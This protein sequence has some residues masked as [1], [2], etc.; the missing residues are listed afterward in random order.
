MY[1]HIF[2]ER[3]NSVV[4]DMFGKLL[5]QIIDDID[6]PSRVRIEACWAISW[7]GISNYKFSE[8]ITPLL[9]SII[10][11][12][13]RSKEKKGIITS[14]F[15]ALMRS[16]LIRY[17][18]IGADN[19]DNF[20]WFHNTISDHNLLKVTNSNMFKE[21]FK[22]I[23][24]DEYISKIEDPN[25]LLGLGSMFSILER[26]EE[27]A[28]C[29]EESSWV[30]DLY[31][32]NFRKGLSLMELAE[33][34]N[35][36][37]TK[38]DDL[39]KAKNYFQAALDVLNEERFG[40]NIT[41]LEITKFKLNL[42]EARSH[43]LF[44]IKE[45]G[46]YKLNAD[47]TLFKNM[48]YSFDLSN[49]RYRN[50]P[51]VRIDDM[52]IL[53]LN[54][55][56]L[57]SSVCSKL[58]E[59]ITKNELIEIERN[60]QNLKKD[61][62]NGY[63]NF[64]QNVIKILSDISIETNRNKLIEKISKIDFPQ[65]I[66]NCPLSECPT[67]KMELIDLP[68]SKGE[69]YLINGYDKSIKLNYYEDISFYREK[70][71][72]LKIY[73]LKDDFK[74]NDQKIIECIE[75]E[76]E[77]Y[78]SYNNEQKIFTGLRIR[79]K[80][81][82][83]CS[84]RNYEISLYNIFSHI[85]KFNPT[86]WPFLNKTKDNTSFTIKLSASFKACS[87]RSICN[88]PIRIFFI[89]EFEYYPN[90]CILMHDPMSQT[91]N[92]CL[93]NIKCMNKKEVFLSYKFSGNIFDNK[94]KIKETQLI[95]RIKNIFDKYSINA[96]DSIEIKGMEGSR[97]CELCEK[98]LTRKFF[99]AELSL[100]SLNVWFEIGLSMA[101]NK[102][103]Y[104]I[105]HQDYEKRY[106]NV[107]ALRFPFTSIYNEGIFDSK[108]TEIAK[109]IQSF[110]VT[111]YRLEAFS[112]KYPKLDESKTQFRTDILF[113]TANKKKWRHKE[114]SK[115]QIYRNHFNKLDVDIEIYD[116]N[117][118][119]FNNLGTAC[120]KINKATNVIA[121]LDSEPSDSIFWISDKN[122]SESNRD[123]YNCSVC[124]LMGIAAGFE[125]NIILLRDDT[126]NRLNLFDVLQF[127]HVFSVKDDPEKTMNKLFPN[128]KIKINSE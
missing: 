85:K 75:E 107:P 15:V 27:A 58:S 28:K 88:I 18:Y 37:E 94:T 12:K 84:S 17:L 43:F 59:K 92:E 117:E 108:I 95:D 62:L 60:L 23:D 90:R 51:E 114:W 35:D 105:I 96:I 99:I 24:L 29:Y 47:E 126:S 55:F 1:P 63:K 41:F 102:R 14:I 77:I 13:N 81:L 5:C 20:G 54:I 125:K 67:V 52:D 68:K 36:I 86:L 71:I 124:Y 116:I 111:Q 50:I 3:S 109:D 97:I 101:K 53:V 61:G 9:F 123:I 110:N 121:I 80:D 32:Q 33:T 70:R 65:L 30:N 127:S 104:G 7:A 64:F 21:G 73:L 11:K 91:F 120:R 93:G 57:F 31:V 38:I 79:F 82:F 128:K 115:E 6:V 48:K 113:L 42:V 45:Y 10:E 34:I 76:I 87:G 4:G 16:T 122:E 112:R 49:E 8:R 19:N 22:F 39:L 106:E 46:Q 72:P 119:S 103:I 100:L 89:V 56:R 40:R 44:A 118:N 2:V 25:V 66:A 26:H 69:I 98:I 74:S 78:Y 83:S